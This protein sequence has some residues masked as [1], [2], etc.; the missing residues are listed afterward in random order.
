[1]TVPNDIRRFFSSPRAATTPNHE[2]ADANTPNQLTP[3]QRNWRARRRI[4][5]SDN[6][7]PS[8]EETKNIDTITRAQHVSRDAGRDDANTIVICTSDDDSGISRLRPIHR[9]TRHGSR[10]EDVQQEQS[11]VPQLAETPQNGRRRPATTTMQ[12]S[13]RSRYEE[14]ATEEST[15]LTD[16]D[17]CVESDTDAEDLYRSAMLGVRNAHIARQHLRAS[18]TSCP[19]CAKF[20]AFLQHFL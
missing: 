10:E 5:E 9:V 6:E 11:D 1:M 14:A 3:L 17:D 7:D 15:E 19:V 13:R 12:R 2:T 20:A 18:T 8:Q 16:D 4:V